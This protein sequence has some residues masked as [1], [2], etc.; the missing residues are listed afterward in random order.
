LAI[1]C[2]E[3]D[4]FDAYKPFLVLFVLHY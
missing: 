1:R 4:I 3:Q 2:H